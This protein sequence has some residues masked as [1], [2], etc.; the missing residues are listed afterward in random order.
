MPRPYWYIGGNPLNRPDSLET[1]TDD[2]ILAASIPG[3]SNERGSNEEVQINI[4]IMQDDKVNESVA[5]ISSH[6]VSSSKKV[7]QILQILILLFL[8]IQMQ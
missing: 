5:A 1:T 3:S 7:N 8:V 2:K 4:V 6:T